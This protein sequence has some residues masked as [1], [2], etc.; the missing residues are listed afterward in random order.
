[1]AGEKRRPNLIAFIVIGCGMIAVGISTEVW[2]LMLGG[3]VFVI[4]GAA[5]VVKKRRAEREDDGADQ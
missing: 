4:I 5:D 1:M 3:V 2:G